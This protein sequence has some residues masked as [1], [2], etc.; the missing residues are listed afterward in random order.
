MGNTLIRWVVGQRSGLAH[1]G[2]GNSEEPQATPLNSL[3][4]NPAELS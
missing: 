2:L 1:M 3:P 4:D